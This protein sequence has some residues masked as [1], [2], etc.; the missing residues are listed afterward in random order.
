MNR[1]D[2][3]YAGEP[4]WDIGRP[5]PAVVRL[6]EAGLLGGA[7]LDAGC[8]TG[9][10]SLY[11]AARGT[12][13]V[14]FDFVRAAVERARAKARERGAAVEFLAMDALRL[15]E[16]GRTF[17]AALDCGLFHT[18]TD[19]E[20]P[21]YVDGLRAVLREGAA[22]HLLCFSEEELSEGGPRRVTQAEIREAFRE[23]F[24]IEWIRPERFESR[25][26][27]GGAR[28]WSLRAVREPAAGG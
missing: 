25:L 24:R 27:P 20:R 14:G 16:W 3:A 10:N 5:Q 22:L 18:F 13:V 23:G 7:V 15:G 26:H 11:L 4:P 1:F 28:A 2:L 17:D 6:A 21:R 8:G 9:E 19:E 12:A